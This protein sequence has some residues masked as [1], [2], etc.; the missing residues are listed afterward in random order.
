[1]QTISFEN[2]ADQWLTLKKMQVKPSTFVKYQTIWE[3]R[4]KPSF[5]QYQLV[6]ISEEAVMTFFLD[7]MEKTSGRLLQTMC[8]LLKA[9]LGYA[10]HKYGQ[11]T[12]S[13]NYIKLPPAKMRTSTLS[14]DEEVR[15]DEYCFSHCNDT[16][17]GI[18]LGLY[19]GLR[20]GEICGLKWADIDLE[21]GLIYVQRTIQRIFDTSS[22]KKT[23]V[24]ILDPKTPSS[25]RIVPL[26]DF[27]NQFLK[28][29]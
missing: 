11:P 10:R 17:I 15:L 27:M 7:Q 29:Y 12:I 19:G 13:F 18:L 4:L 3:V 9:M 21:E 14:H 28:K 16:S 1:M 5:G 8:Y 25:Q 6:E 23:Q 24:V 22:T 2:V 20:I 26:T